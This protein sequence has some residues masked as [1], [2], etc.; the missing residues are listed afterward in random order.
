MLEEQLLSRGL[1][2]PRKIRVQQQ[3]TSLVHTLR[4]KSPYK[5]LL[6]QVI[7]LGAPPTHTW[8]NAQTLK[9]I[10]PYPH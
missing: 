9:S 10:L 3:E 4:C 7:D 2:E 6:Q 5:A 1:E 8:L